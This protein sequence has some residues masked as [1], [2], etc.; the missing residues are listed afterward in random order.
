MLR[1]KKRVFWEALI[2][3]V[4]IFLIGFL[5]GIY[6]ERGNY[7]RISDYSTISEINLLDGMILIQL[8]ENR[9]T[10]CE[11]LK[12]ENINFANRIYE[13]ARLLEKYEES[14]KITES[15][16][17]LHR[18]YNMLRTLSWV[19]NSNALEM[20]GNY[21]LVVYLYEYES[22]DL[23]VKAT[24]SVWSRKLSDIK[25]KNEDMVLLPIAVNQELSSLNILL[26]KY[27]IEGLPAVIVN[28]NEV[29]YNV[30]NF[31][32]N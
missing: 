3:T 8:S 14:G 26:E 30:D 21:D 4:F 24:Q 28:N 10:N 11:F 32:I 17:I 23:N 15:M 19:S 20:C 16:K 13:E 27:T 7:N 2:V 22:E 29:L 18:K 12:K 1:S 6:M 5:F 31:N 25:K 9:E